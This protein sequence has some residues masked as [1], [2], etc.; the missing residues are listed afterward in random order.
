MSNNTVLVNYR[1]NMDLKREF[2]RTCRGLNIS[3]TTQINLL[4]RQFISNQRQQE[5][6]SAEEYPVAMLSTWEDF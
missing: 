5:A 3:M 4:M 1:I 2:E 6:T